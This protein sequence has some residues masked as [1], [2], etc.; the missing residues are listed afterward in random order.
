MR[1]KGVEIRVRKGSVAGTKL[2][3]KI[4]WS[5]DN[6]D[7]LT[8]RRACK[9]ALKKASA[10]GAKTL[11]IPEIKIANSDLSQ[12]AAAKIMAQEVLRH[13]KEERHHYKRIDFVLSCAKIV[14][15]YKKAVLSYLEYIVYKLC[16]G[17]FITVDIIIE[18][19]GGVVLIKRSNPPFGW[20]L[21]GGFVDYGESLETAARREAREETGLV[22]RNLR[23]MHTYSRPG[24]DP[25][26]HTITTVFTAKAKGQPRAGSDAAGAQVVKKGAWKKLSLAFDHQ[27]VLRDYSM[28]KKP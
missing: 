14:K 4:V 2:G 27:Q 6:V 18:T 23:Q 8:V 7:E 9:L 22:V 5:L 12:K 28:Q 15:I 3:A 10:R 16:D 17:P 11:S 13:L 24:R 25:R 1:I 20:A 19:K 21:P 26:F